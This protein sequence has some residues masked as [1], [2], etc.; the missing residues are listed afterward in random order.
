M[1]LDAQ[2]NPLLV[3]SGTEFP[4]TVQGLLQ[5]I[6]E[7]EEI[8]GLE[9]FNGVNYGSVTPDPADRDKA[10][11]RTDGSG[12]FLGWYVWTGA[13]WEILPAKAFVGTISARDALANPQDGML[14]HVV[15][16]GIS[17]YVSSLN[18]WEW[19]FPEAAQD[20]VGDKL[21]F[22]PSQ[23]PVDTSIGGA[24]T[25]QAADM[26]PLYASA[27]IT[28]SQI[29]AVIARVSIQITQAFGG[30]S[31]AQATVRAWGT[32]TVSNSATD[33]LLAQ[34]YSQRDDSAAGSAS[35]NTGYIPMTPGS[36]TIYYNCTIEVPV[37][38]L[39]AQVWVVG[40]VYNPA[41]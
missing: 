17:T 16:T 40:F 31:S 26:A 30:P 24:V 4:G 13:A 10:W 9:N 15:G 3:P 33:V 38:T 21:Y 34:A 19:G 22:C 35:Q 28:A 18:A 29:I 23:I 14:W 39:S 36:S 20:L 8:T 1:A 12:L 27:G 2:L 5:L 32:N 7:Y 6:A 25:W 37:S 11:L 41:L